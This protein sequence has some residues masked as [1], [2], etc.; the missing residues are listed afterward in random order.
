MFDSRV[1]V[2]V[3][4]LDVVEAA[5]SVVKLG[6]LLGGLQSNLDLFFRLGSSVSE[7]LNKG[8]PGWRPNQHIQLLLLE[9][10]GLQAQTALVIYIQQAVFR[11][12]NFTYGRK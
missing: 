12:Q 3:D 1:K 6:V 8:V 5:V 7:T 9:F 10:C 2:V 11:F 4:Y